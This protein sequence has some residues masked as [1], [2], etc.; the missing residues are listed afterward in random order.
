MVAAPSTTVNLAE[1]LC[2]VVTSWDQRRNKPETRMPS[3]RLDRNF[4][5]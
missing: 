5:T 3:S 2:Q 1:K 4:I